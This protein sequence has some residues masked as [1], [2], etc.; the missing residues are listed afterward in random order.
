VAH[1]VSL[2]PMR[3]LLRRDTHAFLTEENNRGPQATASHH[4]CVC[5]QSSNT[6]YY[7]SA[8]M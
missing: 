4:F 5:P 8:V 6:F 1:L 2:R 3:N 7:R